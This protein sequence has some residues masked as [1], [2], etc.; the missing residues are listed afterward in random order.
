ME[1]IGYIWLDFMANYY[2]TRKISV[3]VMGKKVIKE[4]NFDK[5][6]DMQLR[7]KIDVGA[8]SYWSEITAIP[9]TR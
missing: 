8:S 4:I 6:K 2:G 5:L 7:L 1:D 9:N 3:E